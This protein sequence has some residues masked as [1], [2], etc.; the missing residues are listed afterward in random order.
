MKLAA[1]PAAIARVANG[2]ENVNERSNEIQ[3]SDKQPFNKL[4]DMCTLGG[5]S[6]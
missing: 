6:H 3:I 5:Y 4:T 2:R 1:C